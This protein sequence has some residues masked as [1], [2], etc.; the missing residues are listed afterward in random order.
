[1]AGPVPS[2]SSFK[3]KYLQ[4]CTEL[5]VEPHPALTEHLARCQALVSPACPDSLDL[6]G[7]S[8]TLKDCTALASAL[9][10]DSLFTTINL[11]DSFLDDDG[12]ILIANALKTNN[13]ATHVDLRGNSIRA[14]GAIALG[15]M[16][17]INSTLKRHNL[18]LRKLDLR[19]NN[20]GLTGCR[21]LVDLLKWNSTL[22]EIQLAGNEVPDELAKA[23][24]I[25]LERN[26]NRRKHD[27]YSRAQADD[28][29]HAVEQLSSSHRGHLQDLRRDLVTKDLQLESASKDIAKTQEAYRILEQHLAKAK[30]DIKE[31]NTAAGRDVQDL[32]NKLGVALKDVAAEHEAFELMRASRDKALSQVKQKE[33][34]LESAHCEADLRKETAKRELSTLTDELNKVN[35]TLLATQRAN[36]ERLKRMQFEH[37]GRITALEASKDTQWGERVRKLE[38]RLRKAE[39]EY[40]R[41][42]EDTSE[43]KT[44]MMAEKR[45]WA[46]QLA[47]AEAHWKQEKSDR[48]KEWEA[49]MAAL[50]RAKDSLQT[51]L[52]AQS[53]QTA[54]ATR[55]LEAERDRW[56]QGRTELLEE[57]AALEKKLSK[58]TSTRSQLEEVRK[59][60]SDAESRISVLSTQIARLQEE[61]EREAEQRKTDRLKVQDEMD[62]KDRVIARLKE[63]VRSKEQELQDREEENILQMKELHLSIANVI[64][65]RRNGLR[66]RSVEKAL[67]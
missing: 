46:D 28:H 4:K 1:M 66:S 33:L 64:A 42:E 24:A 22:E 6:R 35:D 61:R 10:D 39:S 3:S 62:S 14:D 2:S 44:K 30:A 27:V 54:K 47:Q 43:Q 38:E 53:L 5:R 50:T 49:S 7:H 13:T 8:A 45:N 52:A 51:S 29:A 26:G 59:L 40:A 17:K 57:I 19:W 18:T 58:T 16:M 32:K 63:L 36:E 48:E 25:A 60:L 15:Q 21:A 12:C 31:L 20:I 23:I 67:T 34:E 41:L 11:A 56:Q 9:A 37:E 65:S 55:E